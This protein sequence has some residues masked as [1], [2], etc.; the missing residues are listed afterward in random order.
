MIFEL[1]EFLILSFFLVVLVLSACYW[2]LVFIDIL[3]G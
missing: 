3:R 1:L 2:V